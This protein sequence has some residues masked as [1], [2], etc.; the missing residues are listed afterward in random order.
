MSAVLRTYQDL[1]TANDLALGA[2]CAADAQPKV[3][4]LAYEAQVTQ[5]RQIL[6]N[7]CIWQKDM[8][9]IQDIL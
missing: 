7:I 6:H 4:V 5:T 3:V 9:D 1:G 8:D 2:V